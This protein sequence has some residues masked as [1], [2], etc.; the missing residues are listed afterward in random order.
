MLDSLV[1]VTL[2][3]MGES[4]TE[5]SIVEWRKKVGDWVDE[6]ETIVDVTTDKVDVEVPSTA[7]GVITAL[8]GAEGDTIAGRRGAGRDR[9]QRGEARGDAAAAP[10]TAVGKPG[11]PELVTPSS[12]GASGSAAPPPERSGNGGGVLSGVVSHHARRLAER[13]HLDLSSVKGTGPDGLI[14]R[15]DVEAAMA[16]GTLAARPP[17]TAPRPTAPHRPSPT[18]RS[19]RRPKSP[20]S[21]ARPQRSPATWTRARRFRRRPRS[22]P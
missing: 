1:K 18:R 21:R 15:E 17:P 13:Y 5:G 2:P 10:E 22:A 19:P 11:D 16:A 9:H 4:V 12:Y 3:E 14:L 6:G 8:H 7:A 20:R